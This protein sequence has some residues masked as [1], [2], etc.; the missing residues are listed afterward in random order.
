MG[1]I[2]I[3]VVKL[4]S[5][6]I[7]CQDHWMRWLFTRGLL[8]RGIK[9]KGIIRWGAGLDH[10]GDGVPSSKDDYPNNVA[11]VKDL[12]DAFSSLSGN[13]KLWL[14]ASD[15]TAVEKDASNNISQWV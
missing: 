3:W 4:V 8:C 2:F 14:D 6:R 7:V 1:L 15:A 5:R 9:F 12:P 13:L 11:K 10:D